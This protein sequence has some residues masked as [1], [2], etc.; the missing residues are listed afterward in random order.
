[1]GCAVLS[2]FLDLNHTSKSIL[3]GVPYDCEV[4]SWA[5]RGA[6][7][8]FALGTPMSPLLV[9]SGHGGKAAASAVEDD[10]D[11]GSHHR[12]PHE[13]DQSAANEFRHDTLQSRHKLNGEI[14]AVWI[15]RS[16]KP[17]FMSHSCSEQGDAP[18]CLALSLRGRSSPRYSRQMRDR[19]SLQKRNAARRCAPLLALAP[20]HEG[21]A[22]EKMDVLLVLEQGSDERRD[23]LA[24]VGLAQ[25]LG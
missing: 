17:G 23:Q 24:L 21:D 1:M 6:P 10:E 15:E 8:N 16:L 22:F 4:R 18:I 20:R 19:V 12:H 5:W 2:E 9:R 25:R 11:S 14:L 3:R 7:A 13:D